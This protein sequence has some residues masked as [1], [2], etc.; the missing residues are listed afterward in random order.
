MG[1]M[2]G[3]A[4]TPS[5]VDW[6][7][8]ELLVSELVRA[9][10]IFIAVMKKQSVLLVTELARAGKIFIPAEKNSRPNRSVSDLS[11]VKMGYVP[12]LY[13]ALY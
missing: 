4:R 11:Y 7:C 5:E 6:L 1:E 10:K 3:C 2:I 8:C 9:G 13:V 12:P